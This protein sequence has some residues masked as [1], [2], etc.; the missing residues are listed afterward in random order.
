MKKIGEV[1]GLKDISLTADITNGID[2]DIGDDMTYRGLDPS[3]LD[4]DWDP[5]EHEVCIIICSFIINIIIMCVYIVRK[6]VF[7]YMFVYA[8]TYAFICMTTENIGK[9]KPIIKIV[10]TT[11]GDSDDE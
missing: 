4:D 3:I 6:C 11:K 1:G 2:T 9:S 7:V 8:H 5:D 10:G